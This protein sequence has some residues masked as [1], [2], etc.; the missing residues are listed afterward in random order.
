MVYY[1]R[2][3]FILVWEHT[4]RKHLNFTLRL[5]GFDSPLTTQESFGGVS[6]ISAFPL[7]VIMLSKQIEH[8]PLLNHLIYLSTICD[9]L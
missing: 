8:Y 1:L 9:R 4:N 7:R 2:I 3:I 5:F 6:E